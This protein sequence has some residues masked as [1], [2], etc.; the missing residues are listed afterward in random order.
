[1]CVCSGFVVGDEASC[2]WMLVL[3]MCYLRFR[4]T[5][6]TKINSDSGLPFRVLMIIIVS[7][8]ACLV[9]LAVLLLLF[10]R[11]RRKRGGFIEIPKFN[12]YS[13]EP[14]FRYFVSDSDNV[15]LCFSDVVRAKLCA[16][17]G[18]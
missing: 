13:S 17:F 15:P 3:L 16:V 5:Q 9:L 1:V 6:N 8:V 18:I 7:S 11:Q 10:L 2:G 12:Q 14:K 4:T